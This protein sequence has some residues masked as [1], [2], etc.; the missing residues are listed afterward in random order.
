MFM[1]LFVP[2][3]PPA[4]EGLPP[5]PIIQTASSVGKVDMVLTGDCTNVQTSDNLG[6]REGGVAGIIGTFSPANAVSR[7]YNNNYRTD[8]ALDVSKAK[9]SILDMPGHGKVVTSS[10]TD[11]KWG[12]GYEYIPQPGYLG[13]DKITALVEV[14]GKRIKVHIKFVV[15]QTAL[16]EYID[17]KEAAS[18]LVSQ[19]KRIASPSEGGTSLLT[20]WSY[21]VQELASS[22]SSFESNQYVSSTSNVVFSFDNL[23]DAAVAQTTGEGA[24]AAITLDNTAAGHGW[25][26]DSTPQDHSEYLPTSNPNLWIAREG[27]EAALLSANTGG[28]LMLRVVSC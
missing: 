7:H 14:N 6:G 23:P 28:A 16:D 5:T 4:Q 26:V 2:Y 9:V 15:V 19:I 13:A 24:N 12:P 8:V 10:N 18:C 1:S 25:F 22:F 17:N 27:T 11:P 21:V 3:L 20:Q